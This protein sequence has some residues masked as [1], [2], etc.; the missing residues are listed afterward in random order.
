MVYHLVVVPDDNEAHSESFE[1]IE[2]VRA[3]INENLK[4]KRVQIFIFEGKQWCVSKG[5][6]HHIL[7][8]HGEKLI[9]FDDATGVLEPEP[10]GRLYEEEP[11]ETRPRRSLP[12]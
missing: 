10:Q 1:F 4:D 3:Y 6:L 12:R 11:A 5:P 9:L 7:G 8:P 2:D